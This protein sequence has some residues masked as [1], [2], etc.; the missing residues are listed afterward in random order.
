M[1]DLKPN[2]VLVRHLIGHTTSDLNNKKCVTWSGSD[3][4]ASAAAPHT[5]LKD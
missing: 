3:V 5:H 1:I 4:Q 2:V